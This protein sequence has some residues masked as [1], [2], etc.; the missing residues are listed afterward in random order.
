MARCKFCLIGASQAPVLELEADNTS[1]L[2]HAIAYRRYI[3][4]RMVEIDGEA[5]DCSVM[6]PANRIQMIIEER[7]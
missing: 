4:G 7:G 1:E 3:E 5:T 6:I 2:H